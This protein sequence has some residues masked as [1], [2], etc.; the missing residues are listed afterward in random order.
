M[1]HSTY[2]SDSQHTR[3]VDLI[4]EYL[5]ISVQVIDG[6]L[7]VGTSN[8]HPEAVTGLIIALAMDHW[9]ETFA[10]IA[11]ERPLR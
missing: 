2:I 1:S 8:S 5:E 11:K 3:L 9:M 10:A 4:T 6:V 7:G